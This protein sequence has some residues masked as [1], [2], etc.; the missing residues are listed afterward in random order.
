MNQPTPFALQIQTTQDGSHT[1]H[2]TQFEVDYHSKYGAIQEAETVFI[3]AALLAFA[4]NIA[5]ETTITILEMG[6]GTGLNALMTFAA[7]IEHNLSV[8]YVAIEAYPIPQTI[9]AQL[10]YGEVLHFAQAKDYLHTIHTAEWTNTVLLDAHNSFQKLE[11]RFE[12]IN[13]YEE[14]DIIYYD[15]FAPSTQPELWTVEMFEKLYAALRPNGIL[16]TYCAKG[17]V[18][19]ALRSA[20]FRVESLPGPVGK[21]EMTRAVKG[22]P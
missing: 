17:A 9:A 19:R 5:P 7:A 13:F 22:T 18:K 1:L 4:E 12:A 16:T 8:E 11:M 2:A 3:N 21:R 10:N 14:F 20:G 6:L 15:A